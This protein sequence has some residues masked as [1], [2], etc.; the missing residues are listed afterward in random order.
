VVNTYTCDRWVYSS[1]QAAKVT[2]QRVGP[3]NGALT[4][5]GFPYIFGL[6]SSSAYTALAADH[7]QFRQA[8]EADMVSD[9]AWGTPNAQPV[10]LS[11]WA[12]TSVAGIYSGSL[13]DY[14]ATRSYCFN[15]TLPANV[16]TKA[17]INIPGD[18]GGSSWVMSGNGGAIFVTF[19]LGSGAAWRGPAN[20]AWVTGNYTGV[21]GAASLVANNGASLYFTGVKLEIGSVATPFNRQSLAKSMADCQ[22]YFQAGTVNRIGYGSITG[23]TDLNRFTFPTPMRAAPTMTPTWTVQTLAT[24]SI[25]SVGTA[26]YNFA[27]STNAVGTYTVTGSFTADAEL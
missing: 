26:A 22:R 9:F 14:A 5:A 15:F 4:G 2:W 12:F 25:G 27:V 23:I 16:W 10:T 3:N 11:F 24:G 13:R 17:V 20:G 21:S 18:T 6:T 8:I 19:D 1:P 7:F